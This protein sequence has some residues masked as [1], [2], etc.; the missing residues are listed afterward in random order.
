MTAYVFLFIFTAKK[1]EKIHIDYFHQI[2]N[3][4]F[5]FHLIISHS[6]TQYNWTD[7]EIPI[8]FITQKTFT[9]LRISKSILKLTKFFFIFIK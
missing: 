2:L 5:I 1:M 4:I 8:K 9:L 7:Q 3:D 6:E